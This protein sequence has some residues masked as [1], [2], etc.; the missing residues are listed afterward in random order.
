MMERVLEIMR[1]PRI[2][3]YGQSNRGVLALGGLLSAS[4]LFCYA[5]VLAS[6]AGQWWSN[7]I[8]SYGFLIPVISAYLVWIRREKLADLQVAPNHLLGWPVLLAGLLMLITGKAAAVLLLQELSI[9]VTLTGAV[10]LILGTRFLR[11]L[12]FPIAYLLFMIPVWDFV[13]DRLHH[14]FQSFSADLGVAL[15]RSAGIPVYQDGL[16][17]HLS[18]VTLEVAKA[19]SGV[20]YLIAIVAIGIPMAYLFLR[21]WMKRTVL[22]AMAVGI[23]I[24]GNGVRV[25]LIGWLA[26]HGLG[27]DIHGPFHVLQGMFVSIVGYAVLF[28]GV[29][30]LSPASA[31]SSV[32]GGHSGSVATMPFGPS[33]RSFPLLVASLSAVL[34]LTGGYIHFYQPIPIPLKKDLKE[35]PLAIGGWK[36]IDTSPGPGFLAPIGAEQMLLRAY[37]SPLGD[38]VDLSIAYF[39]SQGQEKK[40]DSYKMDRLFQNASEVAV[41]VNPHRTIHVN[42]QVF[43]EKDNRTLILFWYELNG[44]IVTDRYRAKLYTMWDVLVHRRNNGAMILLSIDVPKTADLDRPLAATEQLLS[45]FFPELANYLPGD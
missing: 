27:G 25:A 36:G 17:I 5:G 26:Y 21:G 41:G 19:C 18:N 42:R 30:A 24:L 6:L 40:L 10:L 38:K 9:L 3:E 39:E 16:Y 20:N 34:L 2:R 15:I 31:S 32:R 33:R 14:P 37:R 11:V 44:K 7:D 8:Y 28:G 4:F 43:Q 22:V 12:W 29:W 1:P 35:F 23:A 13:T 45:E